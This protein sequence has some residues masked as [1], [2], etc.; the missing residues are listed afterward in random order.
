ME[1]R[2]A[3]IAGIAGFCDSGCR[4][5]TAKVPVAHQIR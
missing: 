4:R 5:R 3:G 2:L 1:S